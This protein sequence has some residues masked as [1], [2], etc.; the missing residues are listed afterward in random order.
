MMHDCPLYKIYVKQV[1]SREV[2]PDRNMRPPIQIDIPWCAHPKHSPVKEVQAQVR[3]KPLIC[4]GLLENCP[5]TD[6]QKHDI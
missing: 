5:L 1:A 4:N 2:F 3:P 6:D